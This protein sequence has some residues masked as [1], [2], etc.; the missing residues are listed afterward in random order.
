MNKKQITRNRPVKACIKCYNGKRK[1]NKAKPVCGRCARLHLQCLYS[2]ELRTKSEGVCSLADFQGVKSPTLRFLNENRKNKGSNDFTIVTSH[3][4]ELSIFIS[5]NLFP[6][7]DS[8][9]IANFLLETTTDDI[10]RTFTFNFSKLV[11]NQMSI[12]QLRA[13]LPG[14]ALG[15]LLLSHFFEAVFPLA[16]V[17]DHEDFLL[18]W[19]MFLSSP[20]TFSDLN[21]MI[22]FFAVFFSS[23]FSLHINQ[24][25]HCRNSKTCTSTEKFE[26]MAHEYFECVNNITGLLM[27]NYN[28]SIPAISSLALMYYVS[29]INCNGLAA[30]VSS[31]LR[32]SQMAGLHRKTA[33]IF[34]IP[35][36]EI[37]Y[38]F[39]VFLDSLVSF[40][41]GLP[42]QVDQTLNELYEGVEKLP[43]D[44]FTLSAFARFRAA[45]LCAEI[46]TK[47]SRIDS[48]NQSDLEQTKQ[49]FKKVERD[50]HLIDERLSN[51]HTSYRSDIT[52]SH[53][54]SWL[55]LRRAGRFLTM[56]D[57]SVQGKWKM[58]KIE[59]SLKDRDLIL[60]SL[61]VINES[62]VKISRALKQGTKCLWFVRSTHP[63]EALI[64]V[65]SHLKKY[66][67][68]IVNFKGLEKKIHYTRSTSINY[69]IEDLRVELVES[70]CDALRE[71]ECLWPL[72]IRNLLRDIFELKLKVLP[73][74]IGPNR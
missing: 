53:N 66:P 55:F 40:Y 57:S 67:S 47:L 65:L 48:L 73:K 15:N 38:A 11:T 46:T 39:V 45:R 9:C 63:F 74:E 49:A 23:S 56:L 31:L 61:L 29:S 32:Y 14:E 16:P 59:D 60:Q 21:A 18:K 24:L 28:P 7:Y 22:T 70:C 42:S 10:E 62:F 37:V 54:E 36:K 72:K 4:G 13:R 52:W 6:F 58:V 41:T 34:E 1:C 71:I 8:S 2:A 5:A 12:E 50:I 64:I 19:N 69:I 35:L 20:L 33:R 25:Y 68:R 51:S 17:I 3:S 43:S 44:I 26:I 30:Q 27:T